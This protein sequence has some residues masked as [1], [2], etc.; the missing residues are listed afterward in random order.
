MS[1]GPDGPRRSPLP[2]AYL[3][4]PVIPSPLPSAVM[5][6]PVVLPT[7][8]VE[9]FRSAALSIANG[10]TFVNLPF[11]TMD[12]GALT[13]TF[14]NP[15]TGVFTCPVPGRYT[16][17]AFVVFNAAGSFRS[18]IELLRN[19]SIYK[20]LADDPSSAGVDGSVTARAL[21]AGTTLQIQVAQAS[22]TNPAPLFVG[23]E[24]CWA[25]FEYVGPL[26]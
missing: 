9:V 13:P 18:I 5:P 25:T 24:L 6:G 1:D 12:D 21:T 2:Y 26:T 20:R 4:Q 22:A 19:G 14:Y 17:Q 23:Q 11:D 10:L 8:H 7:P 16:V 15:A 3:P